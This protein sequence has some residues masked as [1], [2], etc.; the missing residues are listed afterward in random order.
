MRN[1]TVICATL[2]KEGR[3]KATLQGIALLLV[4][5]AR[6]LPLNRPK[7]GSEEITK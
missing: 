4:L 5:I 7:I 6:H 3:S 2:I 1:V